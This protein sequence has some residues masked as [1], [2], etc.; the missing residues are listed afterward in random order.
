MTNRAN[1]LIVSIMLSV[2]CVILAAEVISLRHSPDSA[3]A[4]PP[5]AA[6]MSAGF[7]GADDFAF[8]SSA[9]AAR[10]PDG[11]LAKP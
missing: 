11:G 8:C 1:V 7:K 10:V 3:I 9:S 5:D 4:L 6:L 2:A